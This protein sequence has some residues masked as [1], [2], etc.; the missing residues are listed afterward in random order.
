MKKAKSNQKSFS[1]KNYS[2]DP[3]IAEKQKLPLEGRLTGNQEKRDTNVVS[4]FGNRFKATRKA[5]GK[6]YFE[7]LFQT[8]VKRYLPFQSFEAPSPSG[9]FFGVCLRPWLSHELRE[10]A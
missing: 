10:I 8:L 4:D 3:D 7:G 9:T 2:P 6:K 1:E 5:V